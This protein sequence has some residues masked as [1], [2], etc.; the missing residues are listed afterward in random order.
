MVMNQV[1]VNKSNTGSKTTVE[2]KTLP[3]P[4]LEVAVFKLQKRIYRAEKNGEEKTVRKLQ[5]TLMNSWAARCLAVRRITQDNRGKKTAGVDGLKSL[6]PSQR[7]QMARNL[8]L[9]DKSAPVRRVLLP[10][11]GKSEKRPLGIPTMLERARQALVKMALEPQWEALFEPHVYGFRPGRSAHDALKAIQHATQQKAKYVLD[12]DLAQCFD[13]IDHNKLLDKLNTF[14]KLRR[15]IKAW[16]KAGVL[17]GQDWFPTEQGVPQGGVISPL[18]ANIALHGMEEYLQ[19][20]FPR[21]WPTINGKRRDIRAPRL[22]RY[23]D[24]YV[25]LHED[26]KVI[27]GCH[28]ALAVWLK[29]I[30]LTIHPKKTRITHTL[31]PIEGH[32]GFDFLGYHFQQ[33]KVGK[34]RASRVAI[35]NNHVRYAVKSLGFKLFVTPSHESLKRHMA[36]IGEVIRRNSHAPQEALIRALNPL[37]RGWAKYFG[38]FNARPQ[39]TKADYLTYQK[40]WAWATNRCHGRGTRKVAEKYWRVK[41]LGGWKFSAGDVILTHH[42]RHR[43][44][45]YAKVNSQKSPYDGDWPYWSKRR[46]IYP[47]TPKG[48]IRLLQRQDGKCALCGLQI[49]ANDLIEVDH[50]QPKSL[51]GKD[52]YDNLQLL[53]GHCHDIKTATDGSISA[54]IYQVSQSIEEPDEGKL[55]SPVLKESSSE[56]FDVRL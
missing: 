19:Q 48:V 33:H 47:G 14:P 44:A 34:H 45:D 37:I 49:A 20:L 1:T 21:R 43:T 29:D 41:E 54:F 22:V 16:L 3:W 31:T 38:Y 25:V 18:L 13:R 10:K 5:K 27:Q 35:G 36:Q 30:G 9:S 28:D 51:G 50:I 55:S 2:W 53:H 42:I 24:D 4:K 39:L 8:S 46:G 23:A 56:R 26:L 6:K 12:A 40:L 11:P 17:D 52:T 15:Q 32:V 7:L